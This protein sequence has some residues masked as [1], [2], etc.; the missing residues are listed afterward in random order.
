MPCPYLG[1]KE[2]RSLMFSEPSPN[3]ACYAQITEE[4]KLF[5]TVTMDYADIPKKTQMEWCL[6][7][8]K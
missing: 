6:S 1:T 3:N 4:K 2:D 7:C 8:G 5:R